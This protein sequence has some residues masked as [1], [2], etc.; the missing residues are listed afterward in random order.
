MAK[1]QYPKKG[2]LETA[3]RGKLKTADHPTTIAKEDF[4]VLKNLRYDGD[5]IKSI[6]GQTNLNPT[7]TTATALK[8]GIH[9]R[10]EFPTT[11]SHVI[12]A[13]TSEVYDNTASITYGQDFTSLF[14]P[15][16]SGNPRFSLGPNGS[17]VMANG[18]DTAIWYGTDTPLGGFLDWDSVG[19]TYKYDWIDQI[20]N[21]KTTDKATLHRYSDTVDANTLFLINCDSIVATTPFSDTTGN[22]TVT[23]V[24]HTYS[25][26]S[27]KKF[28]AGSVYFDGT[29]DY[30]TV[31]D[32]SDFDYSGGTWTID[33]W[34]RIQSPGT[35]Y[36]QE[37]DSNNY[38]EIEYI[39]L[40]SH[41]YVRLKVFSASTQV[42]SVTGYVGD[43]SGST[44][45]HVAF[46]EN[47]D[48][49]YCFV[50]GTERGYRSDTDR[51]AN[52]TGT[53]YIGAQ[54]GSGNEVTGYIDEFRVSN[55][56]RWTSNFTP[57]TDAY[58][59]GNITTLYLASPL[60]A[61]G[62]NFYVGTANATSGSA[63]VSYWD[64]AQWVSLTP[65]GVGSK[66]FGSTGKNSW[67][68][69]D[70]TSLAK[71]KNISDVIAYWYR[72][73]ALEVN[74]TTTIYMATANC[75]MQQL[76]DLW[77]GVYRPAD[78]F[79]M[80]DDSSST[81]NNWTA[82]VFS[83]EYD[84]LN[85]GTFA[86]IGGLVTATDY[87]YVGS[88]EQL[89]GIRFSLVGGEENT[90]AATVTVE[91]FSGDTTA[92]SNGWVSLSSEDGTST[93][94]ISLGKSGTIFWNAPSKTAEFKTNI[95]GIAGKYNVT[96]ISKIPVP[97][98]WQGTWREPLYQQ[99][100]YNKLSGTTG[101]TPIPTSPIDMYFYRISFSATLA[102]TVS[103]FNVKTIPAP[104]D[105]R[106]YKFPLFHDNCLLLCGNVDAEPDAVA[107]SAYGRPQVFNGEETFK[108]YLGTGTVVAGASFSNQFGSDT[109]KTCL[110]CTDSSTHK[111]V[112]EFPYTHHVVSE[113]DGCIAPYS[114]DVGEVEIAQGVRRKVAVWVAQ[115]G[116]VISDG[117]W[118][119]E[120]SEDIR[121]K[122]D[123]K[124]S[125]YIGSSTLPT[126]YGKID[127]VFNEYHL[128]IPNSGEWVFDFE[129]G[130]WYQVDRGSGAYLNACFPVYNT[131]G[132]AYMYGLTNS[133]FLVRINYG[134]TFETASSSNDITS[135]VRLADIALYN[136]SIM[137]KSRINY[138]TLLINTKSTTTSTVSETR[139]TDGKQSGTSISTVDPTKS[140]YVYTQGDVHG[141]DSTGVFHSPEFSI[142][143]SDENIG[144]KPV[145]WGCNY[146]VYEREK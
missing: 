62:F 25:N 80:F 82:N 146:T 100:W 49:W 51:A 112:G 68:F 26:T 17:V 47:G 73:D 131:S 114:M 86:S 115:R 140:G 61:K 4:Q 138:S 31:P 123:P 21:S 101:K 32:H 40:S 129:K 30:M 143:T 33:F 2:F 34:A 128:V 54:I 14:T 38:I 19:E 58:G 63:T 132:V 96:D 137:F 130:K 116:V 97:Y 18:T 67:T 46:V 7:A 136:Q 10:K 28:G 23:P 106:G 109:I 135:T 76:K 120:I 107:I 122:F 113:I 16:G 24:G 121:D 70:T 59:S 88:I 60:P 102:S 90:T 27:I 35:I 57:P 98:D 6:S 92:G 139:Y 81:Y 83:D 64:G 126:L 44:F 134:T 110:L 22:H 65:S 125:N 53:V 45:H 69:T 41:Q 20:S 94:S 89:Q 78:S 87:L 104:V 74:T 111:L 103:V 36:Y 66:P 1:E 8:S 13:A 99:A 108:H 55:S 5:G 12:A 105:C 50:D 118:I 84:S 145:L 144:L 119:K 142:T 3:F 95:S 29:N 117:N 71:Q 127:P 93:S 133:G 141:E 56:A 48:D 43:T 77:D 15:T 11:E 9:F 75:S 39:V 124:H 91:Y 79:L 72:I 42:V 52:Y 85:E 37:N